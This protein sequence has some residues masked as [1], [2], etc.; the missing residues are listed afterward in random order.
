L[1]HAIQP[2]T[3]GAAGVVEVTATASETWEK[4][5]GRVAEAAA[6]HLPIVFGLATSP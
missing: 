2:G 4:V 1:T 6:K 5:A 3:K